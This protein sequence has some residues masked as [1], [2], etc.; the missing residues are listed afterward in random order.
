MR[1]KPRN[2]MNQKLI[3]LKVKVLTSND[4]LPKWEG[5]IIDETKN[6]FIISDNDLAEPIRISKNGNIFRFY[7]KNKI[8]EV[9][10]RILIGR[11]E[12]RI[13]MKRKY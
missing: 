10:G 8:I 6:L 3:G 13:K 5:K 2:I 1:I 12:D 11:P 4:D 7:V 9:N